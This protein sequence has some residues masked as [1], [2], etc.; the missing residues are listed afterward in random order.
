MAIGCGELG[1]DVACPVCGYD[2]RG[3]LV[4]EGARCPECGIEVD[5]GEALGIGRAGPAWW[6]ESA[7][8]RAD[9]QSGTSTGNHI[10]FESAI[11]R[12]AI[13]SALWAHR[14]RTLWSRLRPGHAKRPSRLAWMVLAALPFARRRAGVQWTHLARAGAVLLATAPATAVVARIVFLWGRHPALPLL[15]TW[16]ALGVLFAWLVFWWHAAATRYFGMERPIFVTL[17][18][19]AIG[20]LVGVAATSP[21]V[22]R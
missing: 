19:S 15:Q 16:L 14:P 3:C 11:A 20:F 5:G 9:G 12:A 7:K 1:D 2:L 13:W 17:S 8:R 21:W 10:R 22:M 6:V 18:V 4:A